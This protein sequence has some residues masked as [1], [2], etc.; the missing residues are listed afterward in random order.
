MTTEIYRKKFTGK[1]NTS[2]LDN[3]IKNYLNPAKTKNLRFV[4]IIKLPHKEE[5]KVDCFSREGNWIRVNY[6]GDKRITTNETDF[7]DLIKR[8]CNTMKLHRTCVL[9]PEY[10]K[11]V[12]YGNNE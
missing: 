1:E 11:L 6:V 7:Q 10:L 4:F 12:V 5:R 9:E 8:T 2:D 3:I